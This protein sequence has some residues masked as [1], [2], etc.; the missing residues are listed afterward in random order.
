MEIKISASLL[1]SDLANLGY[2][3]SKA[4]K[5][6]A[7]WLH[8]DVMDGVFVDNISFGSA[9]QSS[10]HKYLQ[11]ENYFI[12]T[13]LMVDRPDRQ[14]NF[15]AESGSNM[16][17]FHA[18]S[19]SDIDHTIN[20]IHRAGLMA[21]LAVK[22]STAVEAVLPFIEKLEMVLVMTVEP[23]Y[24]GQGFLSYTL[25]K[26]T[27]LREIADKVKPSLMIQVDGGINLETAAQAV[28]AGADV[29]VSGTF[30]F[31]SSYMKTEVSRLKELGYILDSKNPASDT[32]SVV[33]PY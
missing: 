3:A 14:I 21:G 5:C 6:G 22:P 8:V 32:D 30:L 15:F 31:K 16:I 2:E 13:H 28:K 20:K 23:G 33:S 7:D 24:G 26:I 19:Q 12:D 4:V 18:E 9:V 1:G 27:R 10:L 29:L 11:N 25:P 17:T